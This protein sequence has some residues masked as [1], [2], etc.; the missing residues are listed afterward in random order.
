MTDLLVRGSE[1][2]SPTLRLRGPAYGV[3]TE[4]LRI[5]ASARPQSRLAWLFGFSPLTPDARSWYRGA[6]GE[7]Q[8]AKHL[9]A[10]PHEWQVLWSRD[11]DCGHLVVGPAGVLLVH[12]RDHTRQRIHVDG[13]QLLVNGR[14]TNHLANARYEA[15]RA[16]RLLSTGVD[17]PV[18]V[19]PVI[20]VVDPGSIRFGKFR[21][22]DVVVLAS[23]NLT[24]V[25]LRRKTRLER[26]TITAFLARATLSEEWY[27]AATVLDETLRHEAR[28]LRLRQSVA[29]AVRRRVA[30]IAAGV[31]VPAAGV[32]SLVAALG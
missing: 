15:V 12:I 6:I 13:S 10:L 32:A 14:R 21:P 30:W 19:T 24:R 4:C 25:L 3:M 9:R 20:A 27:T 31:A 28:F 1:G 7:L 8:V 17:A 26:D 23:S 18:D 11:P 5:Q 29:A 2:E 16:S 22:A